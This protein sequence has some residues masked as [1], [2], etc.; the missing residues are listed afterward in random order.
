MLVKYCIPMRIECERPTLV[1]GKWDG[2]NMAER[3]NIES[4]IKVLSETEFTS[5]KTGLARIRPSRTPNT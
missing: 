2:R 1:P 3:W 5:L 4:E